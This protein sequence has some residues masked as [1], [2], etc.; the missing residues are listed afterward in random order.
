MSDFNDDFDP[1]VAEFEHNAVDFSADDEAD[2]AEAE[3]LDAQAPVDD[4]AAPDALASELPDALNPS[5]TSLFSESTGDPRVDG[6]VGRLADLAASDI[7]E[8]PAVL[9]DVHRRLHDA[10]ADLDR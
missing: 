1:D 9:E 10:L 5:Q 3:L 8:H 4:P 2:L 7:T 6:A